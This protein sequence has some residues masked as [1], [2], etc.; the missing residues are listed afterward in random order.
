MISYRGKHFFAGHGNA[1][2]GT[3]SWRLQG[4]ENVKDEVEVVC[5]PCTANDPDGLDG[6][7]I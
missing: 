7:S 6:R 3:N 4:G 5:V 1:E 2:A